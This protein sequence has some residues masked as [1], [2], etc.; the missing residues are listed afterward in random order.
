MSP[1]YVIPVSSGR[2]VS[3]LSRTSYAVSR[4][5]TRLRIWLGT[6]SRE[7]D[8]VWIAFGMACFLVLA[9][10]GCGS[11]GNGNLSVST[12]SL[13]FGNV[14]VNSATTQVLILT[15]T[16]TSPVTVTAASVTGAGF[17]ILGGS[18]PLMLNPAQTVTLQI[19]FQPT[20]AGA[21]AG[22]LTIN[23]NSTDGGGTA[24]VALSG[25]GTAATS[26]PPAAPQLAVSTS[27]LSFG[28]VAVNS[29]MTQLVTLTSTGTSAVTV[30][31][32][33]ITGAGFSIVGG[34]FPVTLNP[35][36]SVT[37]QVQFLPTSGGAVAGQLAISS[38]SAISS[39]IIVALSG[40]GA[41]ATGSAPPTDPQL[42]VSASNLNFGSVTVSTSTTQ[43]VTLASTGTSAV[44]VNSASITGAGFSIVGGSF[45]LTL[46]P[47]QTVTLQVQFQPA[48]AGAVAGQLAISSNSVSGG[49]IAVALTGTGVTAADPQLTVSI[50][51][52]SFGNVT[53]N[54]SMMQSVTLK[55]T[56]TSSV[57]V[58]SV[59]IAGA[60]FTI[61]AGSFPVALNPGQSVTLQVQ[62]L[63]ASAGAAAGELTI[64]SNST[65]GNAA[66]VTLNGT[67]VTA[68]PQLTVS[69]A[70]LEF[71]SV[72]LNTSTTQSVTLTSTGT[73]AVTVNSLSISGGGFSILGG[74]FP[75][76]LNPNQTATLQIQFLPT[77]A[78]AVAGQLTINSNSASGSVA[79]VVLSGTGAAS[80]HSV[81]LSWDAPSSSPDPVVGYN[82]YRSASS[83]GP[84]QL[85]NS[86]PDAQTT[87]V[88]STVISGSTYSYYVESVDASGVESTQSNEI[89]VK[90]P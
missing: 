58:N 32:A 34:S 40:M 38:N 39:A 55:S 11:G 46:N 36:Q 1:K 24:V 60:G 21:A 4:K 82:I 66:I 9:I 30:N 78:G 74:S 13:S 22:Q 3:A 8:S 37:L 14:T 69:V 12:P 27:N 83:S 44:T 25:M 10:S 6:R 79:T 16:G 29:S 80:A 68:N 72:T 86:S 18:F 50:A 33:S 41:A 67:G 15:S 5:L 43:S 31:S 54:S 47:T 61:L 45:P 65:S 42:T 56:G 59:S 85:I 88:D 28:N 7:C 57:T 75:L 84:F 19:Q 77:S 51:S 52:L 53:V 26:A 2:V 49:A 87:Y 89:S 17:S 48:S 73:S 62:F 70:S 76:T 71:G 90:I 23:T 81:D 63:P 20:S 64:N 35:T